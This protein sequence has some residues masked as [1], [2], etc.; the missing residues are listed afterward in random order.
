M[1]EHFKW[2]KDFLCEF[3]ELKEKKAQL[4]EKAAVECGDSVGRE[5]FELLSREER[6]ALAGLRSLEKTFE[7]ENRLDPTC[8]L[9]PE[10]VSLAEVVMATARKQIES[11]EACSLHVE[12]IDVGIELERQAIAI[13]ERFLQAS[14]TNKEKT[15]FSK[16]LED[17][18]EHLRTLEDLRF[19]YSDPQAWFMEKGR[20]GLDG[21]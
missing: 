18:R 19:Y 15:V 20:T 16:L 7:A 13:L 8:V 6:K 14:D 9:N 1:M 10:R 17:D 5:V 3:V 4:Y 11:G 2:I 21:A 12:S